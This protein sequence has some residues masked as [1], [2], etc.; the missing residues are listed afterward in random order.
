[1]DLAVAKRVLASFD[2]VGITERMDTPETAAR[3]KQLFGYDVPY[4][5]FPRARRGQASRETFNRTENKRRA[6][7]RWAERLAGLP[8]DVRERIEREHD[9][10]VRLYAWAAKRDDREGRRGG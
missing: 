8:P 5:F 6:A 3:L 2:F 4:G 9:V 1:V 7:L 10:D